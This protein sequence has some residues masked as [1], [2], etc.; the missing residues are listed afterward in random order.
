MAQ[1]YTS[2]EVG[3]GQDGVTGCLPWG[4]VRVVF[5]VLIFRVQA[6]PWIMRISFPASSGCFASHGGALCG[7]AASSRSSRRGSEYS[8]HGFFMPSL[9]A[10]RTMPR[11]FARFPYVAA[12]PSVGSAP[13]LRSISRGRRSRRS[14]AHSVK[15]SVPPAGDL[16][17]DRLAGLVKPIQRPRRV[18]ALIGSSLERRPFRSRRRQPVGRVQRRPLSV[19][20]DS[21][22]F[23]T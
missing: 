16:L 15:R 5:L 1:R 4:R 21:R 7:R 22:P 19:R 14:R 2:H 13:A 3:A 23:Q 17:H 10:A 11:S 12:A 6:V 9:S 20:I 8:P 18:K